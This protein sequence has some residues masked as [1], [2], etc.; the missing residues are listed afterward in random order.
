MRVAIGLDGTPR[1]AAEDIRTSH[2]SGTFDL[3]L[4]LLRA[5]RKGF[6]D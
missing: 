4:S 3:I 1:L 6:K 2:L 5:A